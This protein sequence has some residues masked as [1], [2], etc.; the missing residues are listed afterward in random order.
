MEKPSNRI[1]IVIANVDDELTNLVNELK[2]TLPIDLQTFGGETEIESLARMASAEKLY[3]CN[4]YMGLLAGM[5][6]DPSHTTVH[7]PPN[8][9]FA[10][11]GLHASCFDI[12]SWKLYDPGHHRHSPDTHTKGTKSATSKKGSRKEEFSKILRPYLASTGSPPYRR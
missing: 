10:F 11:F 12:S 1:E 8:A 3:I 6:A 5:L 7:Y 4:S 9:M 2:A